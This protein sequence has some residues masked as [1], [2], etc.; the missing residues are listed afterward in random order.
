MNRFVRKD[1]SIDMLFSVLLFGMYV[2]FLLLILLF[3]ARAY[4]TAVRGTDENYN[5]RT[6]MSYLTVKIRQHDNGRDVF[7]QELDGMQALCMA[8][9]INDR[10]YLTCIYLYDGELKELFTASDS[11]ASPSM[12]T[13][14][15]A[16]NSFVIEETPEG[17]YRISMEDTCGTSGSLLI[18][19][20]APSER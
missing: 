4:Q 10:T 6:A 20:G 11:N 16:L 7:L 9:E 3:G 1:H 5:L 19:P 13:D 12:G 15:A 14:I 8:D 17:F 18:H 2:L